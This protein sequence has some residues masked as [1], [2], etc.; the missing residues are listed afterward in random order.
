[1]NKKGSALFFALLIIVVLAI[2]GA[3]IIS[4]SIY[5][6]RL[7][8]RNL[9]STQAFWLAEAGIARVLSGWRTSA[10]FTAIANTSLGPG[11]YEVV[12]N[13]SSS[14]SAHGYVPSKAAFRVRRTIELTIPFYGDNVLYVA[15]ALD[16]NGNPV[17]GN[18]TV[19][20]ASNSVN[21]AVSY[22]GSLSGT[23]NAPSVMR[24]PT[25]CPL[26]L[27]NFDTLKVIS[28]AQGNYHDA[29]QL[30]GPFPTSFWFDEANGIP[31]VVYL[32]GNLDLAGGGQKQIS[33]F[34]VVGGELICD[35]TISG[36]RGVN[37]CIYTQGD[38]RINGG[39][40]AVNVNG[41]VWV[42]GDVELKGGVDL[43]YNRSYIEAIQKLRADDFKPIWR[44]TQNP[45]P[46]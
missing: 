37:G 20:G 23:L 9:E 4:R 11:E 21:G 5:E 27:F 40:N 24:D 31:N 22:S 30:N 2:L 14:A 26:N 38:F 1:M 16:A 7:A 28:Q 19:S 18:I 12:R 3:A 34:F 41:A 44:D 45:Y 25:I 13:L 43:R 10:T 36:N 33:G 15:G 35:A 32:E 6:S 46:L 42:G 17:G 8:Q 39:G 29:S